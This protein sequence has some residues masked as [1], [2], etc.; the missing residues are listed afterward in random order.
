MC[1][2]KINY[3]NA[4]GHIQPTNCILLT[5]PVDGYELLTLKEA[6][7]LLKISFNQKKKITKDNEA[8]RS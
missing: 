6:L 4:V 2:N 5:L 1:S 3:K 7:R 8:V